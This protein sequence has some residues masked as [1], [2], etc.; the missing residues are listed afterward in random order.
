MVALEAPKPLRLRPSTTSGK[1]NPAGY[2]R[3]SYA[4]ETGGSVQAAEATI[5]LTVKGL[6]LVQVARM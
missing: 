4:L 6:F 3:T 2:R 5:E 1:C